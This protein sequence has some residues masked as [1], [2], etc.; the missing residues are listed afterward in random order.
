MS[1]S[2]SAH[3]SSAASISS[4]SFRGKTDIAWGHVL[5]SVDKDG[6]KILSCLHCG[7]VTRGGGV[8]NKEKEYFW[9]HATPFGATVHEFEGDQLDE[10]N[11]EVFPSQM[12]MN[13]GGSNGGKKQFRAIR[14]S[15]IRGLIILLHELLLGLSLQLGVFWLEKMQSKEQP[16]LD[17]VAAIGPGYKQ[18]SYNAMHVNLLRDAKKEVQLLVDN[19]KSI[20]EEVGCTLM[21]DGWTDTYHR[22]LINFLV[23]CPKGVCFIK[24]VDASDV[25][26][27]AFTLFKLFEKMALWVGPNN[28]VDVITDNGANFK[29][30][31]RMLSEK[32]E[33]ITWS[34]CAAHCIN[35]ILKDI[36][37]LDHIVHLV[38]RASEGWKEIIRLGATRFATTFIAL[39]SLHEHKHDLQA[40]VTDR[41]FVDSRYA[42]SS[43]GKN[44]ILIILDNEFWDDMGLVSK[45]VAPL[46]RL[47]RIVDSDEKPA[48]G[49]VYDGMHRAKKAIKKFFKKK[50]T[51]YKPYTKI[52]KLQWDR[53]LRHDIHAAAYYLN[54]AFQYERATFYK[55]PEVMRGF[56]DV[57]DNKASAFKTYGYSTPHLQQ[58]AI[59][60]LSQ[61]STSSGCERNWSVFKRI[62]TK[63]RNRLEHQ[64]LNDL[65]F[66]HY[67]LR[68]KNRM[69]YKKS[70]C[71]PIDY[72]SIDKTEF[73][74][75]NDEQEGD[76]FNL[77]ELEQALYEEGSILIG[78]DDQPYYNSAGGSQGCFP[79][80]NQLVD[81]DDND[82]DSDDDVDNQFRMG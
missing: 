12:T 42:R 75:A 80:F 61:T 38:K 5:E 11:E 73:W 3:N 35:L 21:A 37:E 79:T 74:I 55:K 6:K 7:K 58:F 19:Y 64:R 63:R 81:G 76:E 41:F 62:H 68:L 25:V 16:M 77:D 4:Q 36:S 52:I 78:V 8:K 44:V 1:S 9:K 43:K 33:N 34:P 20:W 28:I 30:A 66:I 32:Y 24:S 51:L 56:L 14:E 39:R 48:I 17:A 46:M 72:E 59:K 22:S 26:K 15:N 53:L 23:Y 69:C 50:K 71:D 60:I 31:G 18:P 2:S 82:D 13:E 40:M 65:V 70:S 47:L 45:I 29:A 54:P 57:V 10:E 27:D 49:Y 67:N